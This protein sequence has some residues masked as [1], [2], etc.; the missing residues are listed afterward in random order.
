GGGTRG[1]GHLPA[2]EASAPGAARPDPVW[3]RRGCSLAPLAP[4][5]AGLDLPAD[6]LAALDPLFHLT[7]QAGRQAFEAGVTHTLDRR[8]V[9][10]VLGNIALPT[11]KASELA[12]AVLGPT[13]AEKVTGSPAHGQKAAPGTLL[14]QQ[15]GVGALAYG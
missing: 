11:Q 12:R 7:L 5:P 10:V 4:A 13:F 14:R 2:A 1:R 8:R 15:A 3:S 6:L 9:G